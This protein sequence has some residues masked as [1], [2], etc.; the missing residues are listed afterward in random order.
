E[1]ANRIID[2][3]WFWKGEVIPA[4]DPKNI[5]GTR[6]MGFKNKPGLTGF[7][8]HGTTEPE[9][10]PGAV[11]RGCIRM[12]NPEVEEL[13]RMVPLGSKVIIRK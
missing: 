2:P 12:K 6:W 3:P 5:L 4:G 1:I 7:G 8:I 13:F 11:S 9:S 10:V